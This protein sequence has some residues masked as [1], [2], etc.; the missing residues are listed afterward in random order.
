VASNYA[1]QLVGEQNLA[2]ALAD[3]WIGHH[4]RDNAL[5]HA[6]NWVASG[7]AQLPQVVMGQVISSGPLNNLGELIGMLR[8]YLGLREK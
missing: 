3:D 4:I 8:T 6:T 5:I 2:R 7:T 1:V